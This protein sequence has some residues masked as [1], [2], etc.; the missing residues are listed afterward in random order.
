MAFGR[1]QYTDLYLEDPPKVMVT[2]VGRTNQKIF[3]E[4]GAYCPEPVI[5][6]SGWLSGT[7][8]RSVCFPRKKSK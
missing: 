7:S 3:S 6:T 1:K 5:F 4:L 8:V 2:Q